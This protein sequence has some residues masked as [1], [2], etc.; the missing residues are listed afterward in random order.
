MVQFVLSTPQW[1]AKGYTLINPY[2]IERT[3]TSYLSYVFLYFKDPRGS[4]TTRYRRFNQKSL[5]PYS[6]GSHWWAWIWILDCVYPYLLF[7]QEY[8]IQIV[9][10][11]GLISIDHRNLILLLKVVTTIPKNRLKIIWEQKFAQAT[12]SPVLLANVLATQWSGLLCKFLDLFSPSEHET[13]MSMDMI[14]CGPYLS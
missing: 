6:G 5:R 4:G 7:D 1:S 12:D 8:W 13:G 2:K 3:S 14:I 10:P 9:R 11:I